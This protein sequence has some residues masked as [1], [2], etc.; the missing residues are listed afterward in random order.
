MNPYA[1]PVHPMPFNCEI[2]DII[3]WCKLMYE[4]A[5]SWHGDQLGDVACPWSAQVME[6]SK[7]VD[8]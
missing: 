7:G 5:I 6:L 3:W 4:S 1:V 2:E 8:M